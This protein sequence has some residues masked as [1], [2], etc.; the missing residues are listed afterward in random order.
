MCAMGGDPMLCMDIICF[1]VKKMDMEILREI[2]KGGMDKMKE[3]GVFLVGG[4]SVDDNEL[5]MGS[6]LQALFILTKR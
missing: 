6:L 4:H 5:N 3:V 1:P 2:L